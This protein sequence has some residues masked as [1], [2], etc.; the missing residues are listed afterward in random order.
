MIVQD[1]GAEGSEVALLIILAVIFGI[2]L[3]VLWTLL[4]FAVFG[5]KSKLNTVI[6]EQ[7]HN[8]EAIHALR[9]DF[10]L[11]ADRSLDRELVG[12]RRRRDARP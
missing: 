7:R 4:P 1:T 11:A 12:A 3:T 5:I 9:K 6:S 8:T 2:A 10:R